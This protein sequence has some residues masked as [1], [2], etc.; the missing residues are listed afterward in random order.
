MDSSLKDTSTLFSLA[1]SAAYFSSF[2]IAIGSPLIPNTHFP[3]HWLSCGHT[4]PHTAGSEL[5]LAI[6][7]A[8]PSISFSLIWLINSGIF[9]DTGHP[10]THLGFLQWRHLDASLTAL[11]LS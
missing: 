4:L 1:Q 10:S 2:P 8:A 7:L 11:S 9:I 5:Y 3:S 6:S